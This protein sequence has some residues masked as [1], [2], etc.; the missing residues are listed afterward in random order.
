MELSLEITLG[1][2]SRDTFT[3]ILLNRFESLLK[4]EEVCFALTLGAIYIFSF[5]NAK[6]EATR[7]K[8]LAYYTFCF[9]ENTALIT[10]WF[11][12]DPVSHW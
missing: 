4:A 11:I 2:L 3:S 7:W 8:Y 9:V 12:Q 1:L 10:V 5:F 6:D